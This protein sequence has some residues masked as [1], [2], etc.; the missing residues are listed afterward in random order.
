MIFAYECIGLS[1]ISDETE[2]IANWLLEKG[3]PDDFL[4]TLGNVT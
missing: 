4:D 1:V 2:N 3:A